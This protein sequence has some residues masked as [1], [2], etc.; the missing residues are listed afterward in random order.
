MSSE[1]RRWLVFA[2]T[3][4]AFWLSFS[5][6]LRPR[7]SRGN[8]SAAGASYT[9]AHFV[10][11]IILLNACALLGVVATVFMRETH[12]RNIWAEPTVQGKS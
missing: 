6:A 12:C 4:S 2:L 1:H 3:A 5:I 9:A 7:R 10:P 8:C 11:G